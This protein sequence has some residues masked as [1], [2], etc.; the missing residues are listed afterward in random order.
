MSSDGGPGSAAASQES[1]E[2]LSSLCKVS[3]EGIPINETVVYGIEGAEIKHVPYTQNIFKDVSYCRVF[4]RYGDYKVGWVLNDA[5]DACML[6]Q[7][8]FGIGIGLDHFGVVVSRHHCRACGCIACGEC[9]AEKVKI[10]QLPGL[11]ARVCDAC[12]AKH[13]PDIVWDL[14][15]EMDDSNSDSVQNSHVLDVESD[16]T[17]A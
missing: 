3:S 17:A 15:A 14:V 11:D 6:C 5:V 8:S 4:L 9:C 7:E 10:R 16:S 12:A 1:C 2:A 13:P